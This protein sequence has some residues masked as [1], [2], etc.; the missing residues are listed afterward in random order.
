MATHQEI[1]GVSDEDLVLRMIKSHDDRFNEPFWQLFDSKIVPQLPKSPR[2]VDLGCGP[3]LLVRDFAER[4]EGANCFG[5]DV[6]PAM[7]EYANT[8]GLNAEFAVHDL[9]ASQVPLDDHSV[10]LIS[11]AAVLH[12][13]DSPLACLEELKRLL[14]PGGLFLLVDWVAQPLE[15]YMARMMDNV[16]PEQVQQME[17]SMLRLS[18]AHNK[19]Q[20][21][22]WIWLLNKGGFTVIHDEQ[23]GSEHFRTFLCRA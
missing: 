6:T 2:L 23:T 7:I 8:L 14:K 18:V 1:A 9:T 10:D 19:Y 11:M 20:T 5:F 21:V 17:K 16:P 13:L 3:G 4:L 22:D 15:K 12:V